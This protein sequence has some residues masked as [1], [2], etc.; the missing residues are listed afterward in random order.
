MER[1]IA[2]IRVSTDRQARDGSSLDTQERRIRE[3]ARQKQYQ[4]IQLFMEEG[5]TAKTDKRPVLQAML[6]F[7]KEH[8]REIQ[9]LIF[10][11]ID[12]FSRYTEDYFYLRRYFR[13]LEIRIESTDERFDDSPA[14][15][16]MESIL[17][18]Q[19]Q[20]DNDVR[21]ER[22]KSGLREAV[23]QGRGIWLLRGYRRAMLHGRATLEPDPKKA[24]LIAEAFTRLASGA[25]ESNEAR[26][27]LASRGIPMPRSSFHFMIRNKAYIGVIEASGL[28]VRAMPPYL[29]LV[30]DAVFAK[31]QAAIR[32]RKL[33][34]TYQTDH[35][36]FPLRG[37]LRCQCGQFLTGGWAHGRSAR[38]PYYRCQQCRRV[39]LRKAIV[40]QAYADQLAQFSGRLDLTPELLEE[41]ANG[42]QTDRQ[43]CAERITQAKHEI[44]RLSATQKALVLK[45]ASGIIP[46]HLAKEQLAELSDKIRDKQ[47]QIEGLKANDTS[48]DRAINFATDFLSNLESY[49]WQGD[50]SIQKHIQRFFS[51][52]GA[53]V[54]RSGQ[55][56]T[57][58]F[59]PITERD[60]EDESTLSN[61]VGQ[62]DK[63][64]N[65]VRQE[66]QRKP[67]K[68]LE[69]I[70]FFLKLHDT[71]G[72]L[73]LRIDTNTRSDHSQS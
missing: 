67:L 31:A 71:F 10:P 42:W 73:D 34:Q 40:E 63:S 15:R 20:F 39:N 68:A 30:S 70:A 23:L 27:W 29:P 3:Y 41:L 58:D 9:V 54:D 57:A 52:N 32:P 50:I 8:R 37:T 4:L 22:T 5:E 19:A 69:L 44:D 21:A 55:I 25:F 72:A 38:Y 24:P 53:T 17:A 35:P 48:F 65:P 66:K 13:N 62:T 28:S 33:P 36:D 59:D 51:P 7:A 60:W 1:A 11:K 2:Y 47:A 16:Y 6:V 18:A 64:S 46:D 56:R 14:G 26:R 12:R 43:N 49:W 45:S 61:G